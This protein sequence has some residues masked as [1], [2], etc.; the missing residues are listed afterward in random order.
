MSENRPKE[1]TINIS[2]PTTEDSLIEAIINQLGFPNLYS[3]S[4]LGLSE[5]FFYDP[6]MKVPEKLTITGMKML[7]SK[8]PDCYNELMKRLE[9]YQQENESFELIIK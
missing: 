4:W 8:L 6:A 7:Q 3:S 9:E 1:L 5:H 2:N